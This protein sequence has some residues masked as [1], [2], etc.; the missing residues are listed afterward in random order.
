M[1]L[2][3]SAE[4]EARKL[5][6]VGIVVVLLAVVGALFWIYRPF[7]GKP[8]DLISVSI[9]TPYVV[10]GVIPGTAIVSHGVQIGEVTGITSSLNGG[11]RVTAELQKKPAAALTDSMAIDFRPAN[12]FGVTGINITPGTGGQA[13]RDGISITTTPKGNFTLQA[14]LTRLGQ[15]ST[16]AI[17]PQIVDVINKVTR[18]GDGMTPLLETMIVV[19]NSF[20]HVQTTS[21]AQLLTNTTGISVAFPGLLQA[22]TDLGDA[23][24]HAD[25]NWMHEGLG[26]LSAEKYRSFVLVTFDAI[27]NGIFGAIGKLE[28]SHVADLL[29]LVNGIQGITDAMPPLIRP[30]GTGQMMVELRQRFEKMYA[31]TPEQRALRVRIVLDALPG[32]AAPLAAMGGPQ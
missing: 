15:I 21:T 5:T 8:K 19:G 23:T 29:P 6:L 12:Y 13:L 22:T 1:L 30:D 7:Q 4:S 14:L 27:A 31:G 2:R 10:Q 16:K 28:G 3:G 26:D 24:A 9:N 17:T 20:A 32:Q 18:Y 11:A 25:W